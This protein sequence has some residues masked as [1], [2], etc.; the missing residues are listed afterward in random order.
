MFLNNCDRICEKGLSRAKSKFS[1]EA[2]VSHTGIH[3]QNLFYFTRSIFSMSPT[4][5]RAVGVQKHLL[6]S[7]RAVLKELLKLTIIHKIIF[8]A[9]Y[10]ETITC[11][12]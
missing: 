12:T 4:S 2:K 3:S 9:N 8:I 6:V 5:R 10:V 1:V 7:K 11:A